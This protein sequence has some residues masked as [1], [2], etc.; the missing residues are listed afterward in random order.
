MKT[1]ERNFVIAG[2]ALAGLVF[3]I[4][5]IRPAIDGGSLDA[6]F[7]LLG[8]VLIVGAGAAWRKARAD[9]PPK[10]GPQP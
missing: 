2:L 8:A 5:A 9:Q 10:P 4:A 1:W 3:L 7:F 6:T